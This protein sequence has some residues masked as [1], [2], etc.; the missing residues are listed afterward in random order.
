MS[1]V[2]CGY[3][4]LPIIS[5]DYFCKPFSFFLTIANQPESKVCIH[6]YLFPLPVAVGQV[7]HPNYDPTAGNSQSQIY[8][9]W[10]HV[11]LF[12]VVQ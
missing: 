11:F 1:A 5:S 12:P 4:P 2:Y 7:P 3:R 8:A 10:T 9:A 6:G